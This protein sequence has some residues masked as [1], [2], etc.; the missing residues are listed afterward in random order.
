MENKN[1][2]DSPLAVIAGCTL[3]ACLIIMPIADFLG[4][5]SVAI[6]AV[7]V[8]ISIIVLIFIKIILDSLK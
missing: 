7:L 5:E 1:N 8:A 2:S 6:G 3:I 4:L